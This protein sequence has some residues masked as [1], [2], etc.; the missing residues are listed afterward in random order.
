[1]N[2][3]AVQVTA[4]VPDPAAILHGSIPSI[5]QGSNSRLWVVDG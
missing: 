3:G 5:W 2:A 4:V 1:M